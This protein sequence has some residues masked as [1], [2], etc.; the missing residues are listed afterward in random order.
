MENSQFSASFFRVQFTPDNG[1]LALKFD[2]VSSI[3]GMVEATVQ[4]IAYGF[5]A[6]EQVLKPCELDLMGMCPMQEGQI[7]LESNV[8]VSEDVV[9]QLPG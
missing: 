1:T 2:G 7:D 4:V 5:T 8:H 6:V 3:R 9:A